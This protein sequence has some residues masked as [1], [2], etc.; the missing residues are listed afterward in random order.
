MGIPHLERRSLYWNGAQEALSNKL[1]CPIL[2][3]NLQYKRVSKAGN[4]RTILLKAILM[5]FVFC[6]LIQTL[7][8]FVR[9][10]SINDKIKFGPGNDITWTDDF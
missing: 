1:R 7:L 9:V 2:A 3:A 6:I 4:W 8:K 5:D 10:D